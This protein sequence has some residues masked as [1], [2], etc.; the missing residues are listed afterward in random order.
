MDPRKKAET[1]IDKVL[2]PRRAVRRPD[3]AAAKARADLARKGA[4]LARKQLGG[5]GGVDPKLL[6]KL[7][8]KRSKARS[9]LAAETN[10]KAIAA[11]GVAADRLRNIPPIVLPFEPMDTVIDQVTFI[12]SFAGQGSVLESNIGP[13]DNWARYEVKSNSDA[14]DGTGRLS[15]FILW[16]NPKDSAT[17]MTAKPNLIINARLSCD[18]DWAGVASW[19]GMESTAGGTVGLRTTVWGMDSSV[20]SVVFQQ[21]EISAVGVNGGFFGDDSGKSIEFNDTLACSGV[22]V[23]PQTFVLIEVEVLSTWHASG[24]ASA[25]FDAQSGDHRVDLPQIIL[26]TDDLQPPAPPITLTAGVDHFTSPPTVVLVWTGAN[27]AQVDIYQNGVRTGNTLN[28]GAWTRQ[29]GPGTYTFR[30][31]E[32][33]STSVCSADVSVTVT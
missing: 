31:C 9:K 6:D 1:F 2:A 11:S 20:K 28:D 16:K 26:S 13:Q 19:F 18:A 8:A 32:E 29:L 30:I 33:G 27:G 17:V 14:W 15:F 25:H 5:G 7:A 22:V 10:R 23:P 3:A 12:R 4:E 21:D 24:D